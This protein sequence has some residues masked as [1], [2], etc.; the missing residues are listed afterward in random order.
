MNSKELIEKA[1]R[2]SGEPKVIE[3]L[4]QFLRANAV[5][6]DLKFDL[7]RFVNKN[8]N[9]EYAKGIYHK[10]GYRYVTDGIVLVSVKSEYD[11][12][13]EDKIISPKGEI[14]DARF[15]NWKLAM[16]YICM[17]SELR[18]QKPIPEICG[19]IK[20]NETVAKAGNKELILSIHHEDT[21]TYF[22]LREF[23]LFLSF[24]KAYPE[25]VTYI[26]NN[27]CLYANDGDN[28]CLIMCKHIGSNYLDNYMVVPIV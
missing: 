19:F 6:K 17:F 13:Y 8:S 9:Y 23:S 5:I 2:L 16:E 28:F 24:L 20:E 3:L 4:E 11:A 27:Q 25:A 18:L 15:P 26:R 21:L 14:I 7:A 22:N 12:T 1:I 10:D